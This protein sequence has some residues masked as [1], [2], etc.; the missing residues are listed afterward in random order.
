[1]MS[2]AQLGLEVGDS[3]GYGYL[4]P[5][6]QTCTFVLGYRGMIELAHRSG[7]IKSLHADV[8]FE[9]DFFDFEQG[10]SPSL[11]HKPSFSSEKKE[12]THAYACASLVG[13]GNQF[14]VLSKEEVEESRKSS[15]SSGIWAKHYA[16][17]AKKT[18]LRKL[19]KLLPVSSEMSNFVIHEDELSNEKIILDTHCG[20]EDI[21]EK[22]QNATE[23]LKNEILTNSVA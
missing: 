13:G 16:E 21:E 8:V 11:K 22:K 18:A 7:K 15:K 3:L 10:T 23:N 12:M 17:M 1:M 19:F 6:N 14:V 9:G 4:V 2:A 5:Y 20:E